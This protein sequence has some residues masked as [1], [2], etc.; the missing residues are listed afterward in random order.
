MITEES[1]KENK[2]RERARAHSHCAHECGRVGGR[3]HEEAKKMSAPHSLTQLNA[4]L[5]CVC[6]CVHKSDGCVSYICVGEQKKHFFPS[7]VGMKLN[8]LK[9]KVNVSCFFISF[10]LRVFC[11]SRS[12]RKFSQ[13]VAPRRRRP[14]SQQVNTHNIHAFE[15]RHLS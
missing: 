5:V 15:L 8:R 12:V 7:T 10:F 3:R 13:F 9:G 4:P 1:K 14:S 6:I 11:R 2:K